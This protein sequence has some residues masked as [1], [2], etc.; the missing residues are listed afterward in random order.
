MIKFSQENQA[1]YN[2][3]LTYPNLPGDLVDV[4]DSKH[5]ELLEVIN[6]GHYL[7]SDFTHSEQ[8]KPSRFNI[9][10]K[11][12][13]VWIDPRTEEEKYS[14]YLKTL[15][16]LTRRQFKLILLK[17]GLLNS[18]DTAIAS[19]ED[20]EQKALVEIEYIES[21]QFERLSPSV[22]Y[23]CQLLNLTDEQVNAMWEEA[24]L[25]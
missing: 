8:K 9:F 3:L 12:N 19:I 17:N 23:M 25:L 6:S 4:E 22:A 1:F 2:S 14:D 24:L 11:E 10:D 16:P 13:E 15:R 18:I 21:T 5:T 20:V 7:F